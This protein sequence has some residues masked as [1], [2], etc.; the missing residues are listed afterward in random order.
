[1]IDTTNLR[2]KLQNLTG[3]DFEEVEREE[4]L[5][6]NISPDM[7]LSKSFQAR[8][9]AKA[10]GVNINEL[11]DLPANKYARITLEVFNFLFSNSEEE[12]ESMS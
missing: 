12:E 11:K 8:L 1:M 10:L 4:R 9:A 3:R 5:V 2:E 7:S 6:G